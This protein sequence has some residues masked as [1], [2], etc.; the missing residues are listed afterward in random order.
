MS[1]F[2]LHFAAGGIVNQPALRYQ[3]DLPFVDVVFF[4]V[5]KIFVLLGQ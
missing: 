4:V 2:F 5:E 1:T 3:N